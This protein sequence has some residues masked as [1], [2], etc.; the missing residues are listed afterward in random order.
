MPAG[1]LRRSSLPAGDV[2]VLAP[3]T[4]AGRFVATATATDT[5]PILVCGWRDAVIDGDASAGGYA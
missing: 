4:Y 5:G 1:W 2:V 3:D